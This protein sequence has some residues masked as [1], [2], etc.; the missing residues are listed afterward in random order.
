VKKDRNFR[1][2][3]GFSFGGR[4]TVNVGLSHHLKDFAWFGAFGLAGGAYGSTQIAQALDTQDVATYPLKHFYAM[5]GDGDS[6]GAFDTVNAYEQELPGRAPAITSENFTT[7]VIGGA[8]DYPTVTV[9]LYN[10]LRI[11]FGKVAE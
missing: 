11:A 2:F 4:Q 3:S 5:A 6:F 10:F 9:G 8:H 7:H 1:A